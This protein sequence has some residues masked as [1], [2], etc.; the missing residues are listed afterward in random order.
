MKG[1]S[2]GQEEKKGEERGKCFRVRGKGR[3]EREAFTSVA[4]QRGKQE[5]EERVKTGRARG[6]G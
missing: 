1:G 3:G 4:D 6:K 5:K 2:V